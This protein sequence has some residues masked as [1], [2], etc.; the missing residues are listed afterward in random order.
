M[1]IFTN[2]AF[3]KSFRIYLCLFSVLFTCNVFASV[4]LPGLIADNMVIQR[5]VKVTLWGWANAGE[6]IS[7]QFKGKSYTTKT[8]PD[9]KWQ[10]KLNPSAAGGPFDMEISGDK[11]NIHL[12]NILIG[13]VWLC[14]GQSNM[15]FDLNFESFK[16]RYKAEIASSSNDQIRQVIVNRTYS[17]IPA[18]NCKTS[19]WR[20]ASPETVG[21]FSATAYFFAKSLYEKYHVPIGL[22]NDCIGGTLAEA[23]TGE[24]GLKELPEFAKDIALLKDTV[25]LKAK[26]QSAKDAVANW[27]ADVVKN[28]K[29]FDVNHQPVWAATNFDDGQWKTMPEPDFW[30]QHGYKN[31]Y[32]AIWF[33]KEVNIDAAMVGKE[34]LLNLGQVDDA[35]ITYFN[36]TE[37]GK[38]TFRDTKRIYKIPAALVKPGKNVIAIKITNYNALGGMFP[39]NKPRVIIGT[40]TVSLKGD[41]KYHEG[42]K[43]PVKPNLFDPKNLPSSLYNA[44]IAPVAPLD[45]KGVIWYQGE[46]NTHRAFEYR[47][48]FQE[49]IKNWRTTFGKTDLPFIYVQLPNFQPVVD[50]PVEN[51][52]AEL[53]EAQLMTLAQPN[54][55]MAVTIDI[56]GLELHPSDK[57]DVGDRLALA[58]RKLAYGEK[59]LVASGPLYQSMTVTGNTISLTFNDGGSKLISKD[60][61]PLRYFAIAGDDHHFVWATAKI[62][63]NRIEISSQA[64]AHPVAVRYAWAGNPDGCNL[65]NEAGLPASPFR[66][67]NWPGLTDH[68]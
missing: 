21:A 9:G 41:W 45:F 65:F 49:L 13:E 18:E 26:V 4:R 25:A 60:G 8:T 55:A 20:S 62:I 15:A 56:G 11:D 46:Y 63:G 22:V 16:A 19:G 59:D 6:K 68:N 7:V 2:V 35:D 14:G 50:H 27:E 51:E 30:D 48:L 12:K 67:D 47:K 31:W 36:G 43:M 28:D 5:N 34:A 54:T 57:K 3:K 33:R 17:S 24:Q 42:V 61:Q 1:R 64:I 58:A 53:R 23:W 38:N 10:V 52:W 66:T 40:D 44:M 37:I 29:G 39:E 32:G